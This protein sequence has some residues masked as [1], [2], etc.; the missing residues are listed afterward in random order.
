M[1]RS[2]VPG[3]RTSASRPAPAESQNVWHI[4]QRVAL[5]SYAK[6]V[7]R[8]VA[9]SFM[10]NIRYSSLYTIAGAGTPCPRRFV[11]PTPQPTRSA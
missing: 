4:A 2:E 11:N 7:R 6:S 8:P 10:E 3:N 1:R 9:I 5:P